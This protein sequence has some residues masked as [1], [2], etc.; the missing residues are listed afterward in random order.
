MRC[1][2]RRTKS[3]HYKVEDP[4]AYK[5]GSNRATPGLTFDALNPTLRAPSG[6]A[7]E[8]VQEDRDAVGRPH[9]RPTW[10]KHHRERSRRRQVVR[11]VTAQRRQVLPG[12]NLGFP[13]AKEPP[14]AEQLVTMISQSEARKKL[15]PS[16]DQR[17]YE[18]P[19]V[20]TC[21]LPPGPRK[22]RTYTLFPR[23]IR[24]IRRPMAIRRER[25]IPL[26]MMSRRNT[27]AFPSPDGPGRLPSVRSRFR[28]EAGTLL[29]IE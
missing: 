8:E 17:G 24:G 20:D 22:G 13:A 3:N 4:N 21:D 19:A 29:R 9:L 28:T 18:P 5:P 25:A 12:P 7:V 1:S 14:L 6:G 16:R 10:I 23:F 11:V 27:S 15:R 26:E 2:L